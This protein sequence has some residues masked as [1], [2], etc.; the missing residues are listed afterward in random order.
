MSAV[1]DFI[2]AD[3]ISKV[4]EIEWTPEMEEELSNGR[5]EEP[6]DVQQPGDGAHTEYE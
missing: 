3:R 6:D 5:G 4:G 1:M 2:I